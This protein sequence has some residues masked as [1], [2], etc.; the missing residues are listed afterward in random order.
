MDRI[1]LSKARDTSSTPVAHANFVVFAIGI[2]KQAAVVFSYLPAAKG[3]SVKRRPA[4][5]RA[6]KW[7]ASGTS[8]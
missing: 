2:H 7:P 4:S 3:L 1:P 8:W 6:N 5:F